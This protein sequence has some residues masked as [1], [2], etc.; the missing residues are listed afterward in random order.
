MK[1][2]SFRHKL[3]IIIQEADTPMGK[4]F[5]LLL[6]L[7]I[8]A[9]VIVV[10]LDSVAPI[11]EKFANLFYYLEWTFT[12]FFTIEYILRIY[13]TKNPVKN[14]VLSFYGIIDLLAVIPTYLSLLVS[15]THFMMVIRIFRLFRVF[16]ILKLGRFLNAT[17]VLKESMMNSRHKIAVFLE[18]ILTIVVIMGSIMYIVEGP[19]NGFT[20][21]P[22]GIYWAIV[23]LTTVGYGDIAPHTVVGQFI[24]SAIMILGYAIIAVPTGIVS[25]EMIR[26]EN[27]RKINLN[28]QVCENCGCK[29]HDDV[30]KYCKICGVNLF[31][32][33]FAS[34]DKN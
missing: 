32:D 9:S 5:D 30:A 17:Q 18:V 21:I 20:S 8:L 3:H 22:R 19:E 7:A 23:T 15:G 24:A 28:T 16:R 29:E 11:R 13:I 4:A 2:N 34:A 12:I 6:M 14:Y 25:S 33:A 26:S 31:K 27:R 1:N 10:M